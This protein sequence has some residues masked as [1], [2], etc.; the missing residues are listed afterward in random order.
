[1]LIDRISDN[2]WH[3]LILLTLARAPLRTEFMLSQ[4]TSQISDT[5]RTQCLTVCVLVPPTIVWD[6]KKIKRLFRV[7]Q[8]RSRTSSNGKVKLRTLRWGVMYPLSELK[9][10]GIVV[11]IR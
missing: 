1:V 2:G 3:I 10:E 9:K 7:K 8:T 5:K 11:G 4:C 6:T